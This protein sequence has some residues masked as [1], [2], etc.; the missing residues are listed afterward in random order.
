MLKDPPPSWS[1]VDENGNS[2]V[3]VWQQWFSSLFSFLKNVLDFRSI[4]PSVVL[5]GFTRQIGDSEQII[6]IDPVGVLANGS[7]TLPVNPYD[8]QP[9]VILSTFA[10]TAFTLTPSGTQTVRNAP[11]ALSAGVSIQY[12]YVSSNNTW[13]RLS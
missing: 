6:I 9:V 13:Y 4:L 1:P 12:F 11:S 2:L 3:G 7:C 5:T 8:G 10:V